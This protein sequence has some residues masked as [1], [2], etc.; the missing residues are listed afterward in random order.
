MSARSLAGC[1]LAALVGCGQAPTDAPQPGGGID[2]R[3]PSEDLPATETLRSSDT[4]CLPLAVIPPTVRVNVGGSLTLRT[5]GGSGE[6]RFSLEGDAVDLYPGGGLRAGGRPARFVVVASDLVCGGDVRIDGEVLPSFGVDPREA[7]VA[8]GG[9][10]GLRARGAVGGLRWRAL[11]A[12]DGADGHLDEGREVF[13]AG[14]VLGL[15][16][17]AVRDLGGP[18]E[19]VVSVRVRTDAPALAPESA[20]VLVPAGREVELRWTGSSGLVDAAITDGAA[21]GGRIVENGARVVFSAVGAAPGVRTVTGNDRSTGGTATVRV[22]VGEE[23]ALAREARGDDAPLG[24]VALGDVDGDGRN[25]V[26]LGHASA[27]GAGGLYAGRVYLRRAASTALQVVAEGARSYDYL[28]ATLR[29]T[30]LNGDGRADVLVGS[31]ERDL[32]RTNAGSVEVYLGAAEGLS[33]EPAEVFSGDNDHARFGAA[34]GLGDVDADRVADLLVVATGTTGRPATPGRCP[35]VGTVQV[36]R[37][38]RDA[39]R[40]FELTAWQTL[41]LALPDRPPAPCRASERFNIGGPPAVLDLDGDGRV[42]LAV[43]LPSAVA[44]ARASFHGAVVVYRG[45]VAGGFEASPTRVL[46]LAEAVGAAQFGAG[47]DAVDTGA[48]TVLVVRAPLYNRHPTAGTLTPEL[49]GAFWTFAPGVFAPGPAGGPA[50]FATTASA[51][52]RFVGGLNQGVGR[53]AAVGDADGD[54]ASD[55]VV[56]GWVPGVEDGR[57]WTFPVALLRGGAPA[58]TLPEG[59]PVTGARGERF[60]ADLAAAPAAGAADLAVW[61]PRR[62]TGDGLRAGAL[63]LAASGAATAGNRFRDGAVVPVPQRPAGDEQGAAVALLAEDGRVAVGAPGAHARE[64][65][66]RAGEVSTVGPDG[67]STPVAPG[68]RPWGRFGRALAA[69]DFDGDGRADLAVGDPGAASGGTDAVRAGRVAMPSDPGCLLRAAGGVAETSPAGRGLVRIFVQRADGGFAERFVAWPRETGA[70][71]LEERGGFGLVVADAG[72]VNGDGRGDLLVG[73][74]ADRASNGAEVILGRAVDPSGRAAVVCGDPAA[75]P[76]WPTRT[77]GSAWGAVAGVGDLDGDGCHDVAASVAGALRA[78]VSV[79]FGFGPR[80]RGGPAPFELTVVRDA[81]RLDNNRVGDLAARLDDDRE[82]SP[83]LTFFGEHLAGVG[84]VTGDRAPDLAVRSASRALGDRT[85]PVVHVLS[86]AW[87][88]GLCPARRCPQGRTGPL[89]ADGDYRRVALQDV[90]APAQPVLALAG[91]TA[92]SFGLALAGADLDGD[93][94]AELLAGA[95]DEGAPHTPRGAVFAWRGGSSLAPSPW[96]RA[97]G[98]GEPSLFGAALAVR[99]LR[100]GGACL[101]VGA[102]HASLLGPRVGAVYRWRW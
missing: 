94:V 78:A 72:D 3:A 58:V 67:A 47:T 84:D 102:P 64:G 71:G 75:A 68:E 74:A 90:P 11:E 73:H 40:P 92:P 88:S 91:D 39:R 87:L 80:C 81:A 95:P 77:D 83:G 57:L 62:A 8:P 45:L 17:W 41:D 86:G 36:F 55:Y 60:G 98:D 10:V 99:G 29:V 37:G 70:P 20:W 34:L 4:R 54:G 79:R 1:A 5:T 69:L 32:H 19:A 24:A 25:D 96:L 66:S 101:V 52:A 12:P 6:V 76:W 85:D 44:T 49:R 100:G 56:S 30:D 42:D 14:R 82:R 18:G 46:E 9:V 31:P 16:R 22:V 63:T 15:Y 21:R 65:P 7:S 59:F 28:G 27:H 43:G 61:S 26:V 38:L 33:R 97:V 23:R 53:A 89:W 93:G 2:A 48:G 50:A 35:T 51:R 13:T